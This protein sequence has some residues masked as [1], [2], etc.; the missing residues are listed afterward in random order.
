MRR[1]LR[2]DSRES[3]LFSRRAE[4]QKPRGRKIYRGASRRENVRV[5]EAF[6][7]PI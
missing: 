5:I 3:M 6:S 7:R 2:G 4:K 1:R